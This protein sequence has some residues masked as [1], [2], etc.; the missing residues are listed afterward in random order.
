MLA[1][2]PLNTLTFTTPQALGQW[3]AQH[4][5][6]E[7]E[8]WVKIYKKNTG[9][10]SVSWQDVVIESLC[11]G[12]IDGIKK[13]VDAN[14]YLQRITPRTPRSQ[15]SKKNTE[16]VERLLAAGRMMPP[17]LA[18]V[19]AA[20]VDGRWAKAYA[21]S[22]MQVPAD[23]ITALEGNVQASTFFATLTK[24]SRYVIAYGLISARKADT[25]LRRFTKYMEMLE[26]G[27]KPK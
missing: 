18:V 26:L 23:F 16:H 19:T 6:G 5:A 2:M 9:V 14:T 24:S 4:H 17:G 13:S 12:W 20:K 27:E 10:P 25:R 3:L 11:W 21:A 7:T 8:L 1:P 22:E 15:W